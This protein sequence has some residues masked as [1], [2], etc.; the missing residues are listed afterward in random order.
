MSLTIDTVRF[1]ESNSKQ[2]VSQYS[3]DQIPFLPR[4]G[5]VWRDG[6]TG[7]YYVVMKLCYDTYEGDVKIFVAA[8]NGKF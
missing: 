1:I 4:V 6:T 8:S 5:E 3:Y 7:K 2:E